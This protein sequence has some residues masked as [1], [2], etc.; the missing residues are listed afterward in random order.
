MNWLDTIRSTISYIEDH[1]YDVKSADEIAD[2]VYLSSFYLQKGFK[3]MTGYSISEYIKNRRLYL[4]A[5]ELISS[6][7]KIIDI[8]YKFGYETPES[9]TKAFN[10]FHG[11]NPSKIKD[12]VKSVKVFLPLKITI[13]IQG[14]K[15]MNYTIEKKKELKFIG[16]VK[17]FDMT[18]SYQ[19]IPKYWDE[20]YGNIVAPLMQ[21]N[22]NP[23]ND[24][25]KAIVENSIGE[26]GVC[27]DDETGD[28][29]FRYMIAGQYLGGNVPEGMIV[30]E[31]PELEW[32]IFKAIG[33][34]PGAL[35]SVNTKIFKEWLPNSNY[36]ISKQI[37]VEWYSKGNTKD[38]NYES[39][40]W[41]PVKSN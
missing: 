35:Q 34:M 24:I 7:D 5:M 13:V 21:R 15:E 10:R 23:A 2:E 16:F 36:S 4:A 30:Y 25:E 6:N 22:F 29:K 1:L 28:G 20:I 27:I 9:F 41:I 3:L 17:E 33:P 37:N 11:F 40:I 32:A 14:G 18:T 39:A 19:D 31:A 38:S 12:N 8:A 26:F